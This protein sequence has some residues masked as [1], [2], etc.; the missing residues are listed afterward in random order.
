MGHS[1]P[2]KFE[3]LDRVQPYVEELRRRSAA[4]IACDKDY[5]YIRE[6]IERFKQHEADK[7]ISL[8]EQA[9][10]KET[11]ELDARSKAR[12]KERRARPEPP[13]KVYELTLQNVDQAGLPAPLTWTNGT[14]VSLSPKPLTTLDGAATNSASATPPKPAVPDH[15]E[16]LSDGPGPTPDASLDEA[17]H[18]LVDYLSLLPKGEVV[19]TGH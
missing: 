3:H 15:T 4:R 8:S 13:E 10:L 18:I 5:S 19:T 2:A 1:P 17:E 14:M 12:D 7:T 9:R 11:E 16:D 6:D